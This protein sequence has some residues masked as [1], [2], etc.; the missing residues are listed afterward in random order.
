MMR[1]PI[2][3]TLLALV[4]GTAYAGADGMRDMD[5]MAAEH[6]GDHPT[7]TPAATTAPKIPVTGENVVYGEV[8]GKKLNGFLARPKGVSGPLPG[9]IVI[10]EWWG[11]NDN[12]RDMARRLAGEGY[13]ALAV[14]LYGGAKADTPDQAT[15]LMQAAMKD[16][17][18]GQDNLHQAYNYLATAQHAPRIGVIGWCFGGGWSLATA[19]L[20]PD[21]IAATVIYYG[22]LETDRAKLATLKMPILGFFGGQDGSIPVATIRQF[23]ST[24]KELG[25]SVE[26]H[27]YENAKHAFANASGGNYNAEAASDSWKRTV[28]FLARN[29]KK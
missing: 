27:I 21:K 13:A 7:A 29:L 6:Q 3:M 26:I 2:F 9:I 20:L 19:L 17:A 14:D 10:H 25:K 22:H 12:I 5:K 15:A 1:A 4:L 16:M 24:L 11:L 18:A 8:G 28:E 23:E